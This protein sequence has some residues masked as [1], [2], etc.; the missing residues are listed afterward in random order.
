MCLLINLVL[1]ELKIEPTDQSC[2]AQNHLS[3]DNPVAG[4]S[5]SCQGESWGFVLFVKY[6]TA[7]KYQPLRKTGHFGSESVFACACLETRR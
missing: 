3:P 7:E 2:K 1:T 4:E 6:K 5:F